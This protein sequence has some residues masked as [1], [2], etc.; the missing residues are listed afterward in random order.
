MSDLKNDLF[1]KACFREP[2]ERTPVWMMRQA[3]RYLPEYRAVR[4]KHDFITM[5]KTPE[6]AAEV[7]LQPVDILGVDAA[8]L[9][10]DILVVPEA[11]GMKLHFVEGQGPL[12]PSPLRNE[13]DLQ[14][15]NNADIAERLSFV[16]DA[17]RLCR[18]ELEGGVP[19]IGFAGAP[20]TL[21]TYMIEGKGSKNFVEAKTWRYANPEAL[22]KLMEKITGAVIEY[23]SG[24]IE[25]G[26]QAIQLFDSWAGILDPAGFETFA[27]PYVKR[28]FENVR[29]A[30][31]PL[32]YFA[33][34]AGVWPR[35][36]MKTGAD[37]LGLDWNIDLGEF[38]RKAGDRFALQGNLDPVALF[39]QPPQIRKQVV[40]VLESYGKGSGHIFNLGHGIL[41][42]VPVEHARSFIEAVKEESR[43]FH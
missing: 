12:F 35:S 10:S 32:I 25:A 17:I 37:V 7:T 40:K 6:L 16:F 2:V 30:G 5:Y 34:G 3:G 38:R 19:L 39:S 31:V 1:I 15:L 11:M 28:I 41:P 18:K 22:H 26:A 36:L 27:I 42:N 14:K 4:R 24:Q 9:F 23:V 43:N 13:A 29:T 8:I 20:W 33:K 21:A